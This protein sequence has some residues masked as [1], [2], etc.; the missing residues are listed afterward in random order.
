MKK[1]P[2]ITF[3]VRGFLVLRDSGGVNQSLE[4][5]VCGASYIYL[6]LR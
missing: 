1:A 2:S 6:L 4:S 3:R 5:R